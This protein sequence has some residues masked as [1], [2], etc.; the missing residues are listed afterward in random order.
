LNHLKRARKV[1]ATRN[2]QREIHAQV[3]ED[4][5]RVPVRP[6]ATARSNVMARNLAK[7]VDGTGSLSCVL[8]QSDM[9]LKIHQG[10][11]YLN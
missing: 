6:V 2:I 1:H 9:I 7:L 4:L 11:K 5:N 3:D 8:T 10:K